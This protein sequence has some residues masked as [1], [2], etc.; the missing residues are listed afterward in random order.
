MRSGNALQMRV[1]PLALRLQ[2][3]EKALLPER[4][5]M[6]YRLFPM[7]QGGQALAVRSL[8]RSGIWSQS[9]CLCVCRFV[10]LNSHFAGNYPQKPSTYFSC[11]VISVA[12]KKSCPLLMTHSKHSGCFISSFHPL[13]Y[14][15]SC[16]VKSRCWNKE[17]WKK[18]KVNTSS[19]MQPRP[20]AAVIFPLP[21]FLRR[22][23]KGS[24]TILFHSAYW[25]ASRTSR[26]VFL[27]LIDANP[28]R[29]LMLNRDQ[30]DQAVARSDFSQPVEWWVLIGG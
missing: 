3:F 5:L 17:Q 15:Y 7:S 27:L 11:S 9:V 30:Y 2:R 20:L 1:A 16:A 13:S 14:F 28:F 22:S 21:L 10:L 18:K 6:C 19:K 4:N 12:N 25:T 29:A 24:G 8:H 23:M 26:R